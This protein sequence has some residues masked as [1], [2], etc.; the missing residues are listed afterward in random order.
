MHI[1]THNGLF[2]YTV[3]QKL[4][5]IPL[6]KKSLYILK[7]N[8]KQNILYVTSNKALLSSYKIIIKKLS[9]K[10]NK[11]KIIFYFKIRH[12]ER[13]DLALVSWNTTFKAYVTT[14]KKTQTCIAPGQSIVFYKNNY[15]IGGAIIH[16]NIYINNL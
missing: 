1:G 8:N 10:F 9:F 5:H 13:Q 4:R 11:K 12:S 6:E 15:C 3:G 16:N 2:F 14:F 7:K